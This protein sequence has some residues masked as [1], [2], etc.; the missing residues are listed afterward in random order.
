M[1]A[2]AAAI[3]APKLRR[4]NL[5][6]G[7]VGNEHI[8]TAQRSSYDDVAV[9]YHQLWAD[10]YLPAAM[11]AL[12][13]LFF[14]Q[15][16]PGARVLDLCCGSGHV[17]KELVRR[18][19][20]VTGVDNSAALIE[21]AARE[22]PDADL[23]VSDARE[24]PFDGEFEA[25][26]STFD[27]LNHILELDGLRRAIAGAFRALRCGGLFVF[28]MNLEEAYTADLH[29]W[30]VD[31]RENSAGLVR[32]HFDMVTKRASTELVWFVRESGTDC[33]RRKRS[34]VEQ[35]CY[36]LGAILSALEDAGFRQIESIPAY[37]AGVKSEL[38]FGRMYFRARRLC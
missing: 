31:L 9:M 34:T 20:R 24:L 3:E 19:Y 22:L 27:S 5:L 26:L 14:S 30:S 21:L 13:R 29:Q 32:G 23:R 7:I 18:G 11:P 16:K 10:W 36:P 28:D 25:A 35:Q 4:E 33:W 6:D 2:P 8:S 37:E 1:P 17:T 12:E 15:V 38:G